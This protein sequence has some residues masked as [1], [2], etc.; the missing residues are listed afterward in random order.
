MNVKHITGAVSLYSLFAASMYAGSYKHVSAGE[1]NK[2]SG[3]TQIVTDDTIKIKGNQ[4]KAYAEVLIKKDSA[5]NESASAKNLNL[6]T[7]ENTCDIDYYSKK[8]KELEDDS[9]QDSVDFDEDDDFIIR[10]FQ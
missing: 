8:Y 2:K 5:N 3:N 6:H 10:R 7:P 1:Y 9:Q 4:D